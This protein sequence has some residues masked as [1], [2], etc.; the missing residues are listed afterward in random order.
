M[1]NKH[2]GKPKIIIVDDRVPEGE[3]FVVGGSVLRIKNIGIEI[4]AREDTGDLER[5]LFEIKGIK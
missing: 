5:A 3:I 2:P 1:E 4:G